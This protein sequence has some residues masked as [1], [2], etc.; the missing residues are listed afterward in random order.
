[1]EVSGQLHDPTALTPGKNPG[2]HSIGR[3]DLLEKRNSSSLP[4]IESRIVP[5]RNANSIKYHTASVLSLPSASATV[6]GCRGGCRLA[7]RGRYR[8]R[9]KVK[10]TPCTKQMDVY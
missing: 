6:T 1:M 10:D 8:C 9:G 3:L 5:A 2:T 4:G 7:M